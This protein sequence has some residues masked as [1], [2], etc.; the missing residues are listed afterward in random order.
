MINNNNNN[1]NNNNIIFKNYSSNMNLMFA[2]HT[3]AFFT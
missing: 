2:L 3:V 1:N